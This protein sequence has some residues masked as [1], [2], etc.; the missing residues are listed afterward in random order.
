MK[1]FFPTSSLNFNDIFAT[2]SISPKSYYVR[3]T[4]GTKRN[5]A[6]EC[7]INEDFLVLFRT[8][9]IFNL[10]SNSKTIYDEYPMILELDLDIDEYDI[11]QINKQIYVVNRTIY[12]NLDNVRL[13]FLEQEHMQRVIQK[14]KLVLETKSVAKYINNF[15]VIDS[16]KQIVKIDIPLNIKFPNSKTEKEL[17]FDRIFNSVKGILYCYLFGK[18]L[19]VND[20]IMVMRDIA[21][22]LNDILSLSAKLKG[23]SEV[24]NDI[25]LFTR[26]QVKKQYLKFN[27]NSREN[28]NLNINEIFKFNLNNITFKDN[29]FN[30]NDEQTLFEQILIYLTN[31]SKQ[32]VGNLEKSEITKL[33]NGITAIA[34]TSKF[35]NR[36]IDDAKFIHARF[37][38]NNFETSIS[39]I[40][41]VVLQNFYAFILKYNN[42]DELKVYL[43]EKNVRNNFILYS[44]MG[45]FIGYS[46][47]DR[48]Y[49]ETLLKIE[50]SD[51]LR[52]ID[53]FL[54]EL[55]E[56]IRFSLLKRVEKENQISMENELFIVNSIES[57][58]NKEDG[59]INLNEN[60]HKS[61]VALYKEIQFLKQDK[62]IRYFMDTKKFNFENNMEVYF[63]QIE[64]NIKINLEYKNQS[65]EILLVHRKNASKEVLVDYKKE[66]R[67]LGVDGNFTRGNYPIVRLYNVNSESKVSNKDEA[68]LL[69]C[70][71]LLNKMVLNK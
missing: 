14:S 22:K 55:Q 41:S 2:E 34:R 1:L 54:K 19:K 45:A 3:R 23:E 66:L 8:I 31:N 60:Y 64:K 33:V 16:D 63:E 68:A 62:A 12:L 48:E 71:L 44:F 7:A 39:N 28:E 10:L 52:K 18:E 4:F 67:L 65:F 49:T 17:E 58:F 70:L 38:M 53:G 36:Y 43:K 37:I 56:D 27:N 61:S 26:D 47:L 6:T 15:E 42:L 40:K 30:D 9:P 51:L 69:E 29:L 32:K 20:N 35:G 11:H 46:G 21:F 25:L 24:V 5:F 59:L 13:L 57:N 50:N